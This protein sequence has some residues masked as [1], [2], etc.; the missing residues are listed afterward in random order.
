MFERFSDRA[1]RVIVLAQEEA[2]LLAHDYIGTEHVLLGLL[3]ESQG[4]AGQALA[5]SGIELDRVRAQVGERVGRGTAAPPGHIPF[6]PRAKKVLELSLREALQ[7]GHDYIGT[8]HI[9]L[10]LIREGQGLAAQILVA[11]GIDLPRLR[12]LVLQILAGEPAGEPTHLVRTELL[13]KGFDEV[14]KQTTD[15]GHDRT[16][17]EHILLWLLAQSES[18]A[19]LALQ[20]E[21]VDVEALRSRLEQI[22]E[23]GNG[24]TDPPARPPPTAP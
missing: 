9:L 6:T 8:E 21:G 7:L 11:L 14:V 10:G 15:R 17:S 4:I 23:E 22:L 24:S 12:E 19:V 3:H 18:A 20:A 1:R 5:S 13:V 16:G 2:R